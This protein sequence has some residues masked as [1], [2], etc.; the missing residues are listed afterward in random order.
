MFLPYRSCYSQLLCSNNHIFIC[1]MAWHG[2][3]YKITCV[4]SQC[5]VCVSAFSW[6]Q[7]CL[8]LTKF[9]T[10][11]CNLKRKNPFVGGSTSSNGIPYFYPH[12][13]PNWHLC[14]AFSVRELKR[15]S[16]IVCKP[17]IALRSSNNVPWWPPTL[18]VKRG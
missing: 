5:L 12:F 7:F 3:G 9:G 6:S 14:S 18:N 11:V 16:R 13:T 10:G 1:P 17:I 8:I 4:I 2:T 15:C